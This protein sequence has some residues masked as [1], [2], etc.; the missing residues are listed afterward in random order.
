MIKKPKGLL[1]TD[2]VWAKM[3]WYR[4]LDHV[5][6]HWMPSWLFTMV[7]A[8]CGAL[9]IWTPLALIAVFTMWDWSYFWT[10]WTRMWLGIWFLIFLVVF[11]KE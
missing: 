9:I 8:I 6:T 4:K 3:V 5:A 7:A 10:W 11:G 1:Y 2:E